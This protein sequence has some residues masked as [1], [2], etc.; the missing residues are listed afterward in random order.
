MVCLYETSQQSYCSSLG[1]K[2]SLEYFQT[3]YKL[4]KFHITLKTAEEVAGD[5]A[6]YLAQTL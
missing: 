1:T 6:F 3:I 5:V 4:Q 2:G